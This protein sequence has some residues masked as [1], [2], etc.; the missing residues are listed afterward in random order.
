ML[1]ALAKNGGVIQVCMVGEYLKEIPF[2]FERDS[3]RHA[4]ISRYGNYYNL[5]PE[6]QEEFLKAWTAVDSIFP[7]VLATVSDFVDHIDHI[8]QVAG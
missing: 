1:V 4:V 7:P 3:A 2:S 5:T 6:K 8:V